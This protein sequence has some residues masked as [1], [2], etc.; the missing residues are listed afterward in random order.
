MQQKKML[1]CGYKTLMLLVNYRVYALDTIS[2]LGKS[3]LKNKNHYPKSAQD[4]SIWLDDV[5]DGLG[6][7][8]AYVIGS[9]MGGW[10]AHGAAIFYTCSERIKKIV[11]IDPAAGIPEKTKWSR[12]F[13][14]AV[15]LPVKWNYKRVANKILGK[16]NEKKEF[17]INYMVAA[18]NS[19]VKP[20]LGLPSK[21]SDEELKKTKVP[22]LLLIG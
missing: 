12:L 21:F 8:K 4:Y 10:I 18:F 16:S 14:I 13:F 7:N 17:W 15:I 5:L 19:K 11:L 20:K 3:I 6:V 1:Q 2:D 9:L 22:T